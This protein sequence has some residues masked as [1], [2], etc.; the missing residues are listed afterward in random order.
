[1]IWSIIDKNSR[2]QAGDRIRL[3]FKWLINYSWL[4]A[5]QLMLIE[6]RLRN[7]YQNFTVEYYEWLDNG[8]AI[9]ITIDPVI[10]SV[11]EAGITGV[12]IA[13]AILG[14]ALIFWLS[15][16]KIEKPAKAIEQAISTPA[17]QLGA[18]ALLV[19]AIAYLILAWRKK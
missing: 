13:A 16:D 10:P 15:L 14:T 4:Q 17:A 11:Q 7:K 19:F 1:M 6:S 3:T 2:L 9:I 18:G 5:A 12:I 8:V